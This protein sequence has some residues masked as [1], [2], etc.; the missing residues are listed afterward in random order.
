MKLTTHEQVL[1]FYR[2]F[3]KSLNVTED[4]SGFLT[5]RISNSAQPTHLLVKDKS[6]PDGVDR[7]LVMPTKENLRRLNEDHL[8]EFNPLCE[9]VLRGE[10]EVLRKL[11]RLVT[12]RINQQML[13]LMQ[14]ISRLSVSGEATKRLNSKQ[15]ALIASA[16]GDN[17]P[18]DGFVAKLNKSYAA[19]ASD[20]SQTLP[21]SIY[22]K[23]DAKQPGS[24]DPYKRAAIVTFPYAV[25][26]EKLPKVLGGVTFAQYEVKI[27]STMLGT[28]L[29][30]ITD[31]DSYSYYGNPATVPNFTVLAHAW[32]NIATTLN[33]S[34]I[35]LDGEDVDVEKIDLSWFSK[36][37][38]LPSWAGVIPASDANKGE[39]EEDVKERIAAATPQ[40]TELRPAPVRTTRPMRHEEPV[41]TQRTSSQSSEPVRQKVGSAPRHSP[42]DR[43]SRYDQPRQSARQEQPVR[44][45]QQRSYDDREDGHDLARALRNQGR[46]ETRQRT[47]PR[48]PYARRD[49]RYEDDYDKGYQRS[50]GNR[51][52]GV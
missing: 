41:S 40:R 27:I 46:Q 17:V 38:Q 25:E 21:V 4:E 18:K 23:R 19:A 14:T 26:A 15:I 30:G 34:L 5:H 1:E 6:G 51:R 35:L 50:Y 49:S 24:V 36:M 16:M 33:E 52:G 44:Y 9:S 20:K 47:Q 29:P 13:V 11:K 8:V 31:Q 22:I 10:S 28:L 48:D 7:P 42:Y 39:G 3:L 12:F 43:Q 45:G 37:N 32:H 2:A